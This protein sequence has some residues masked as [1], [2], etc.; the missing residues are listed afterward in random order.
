QTDTALYVATMETAASAVEN[1]LF[2]NIDNTRTAKPTGYPTDNTT[3][4]NAY[5]AKLN[6]SNGQK[7]GPSLV[8]RVMA[9]DSIT[10]A[11][12][13]LY[14][15]AGASTPY[16]TSSSMVTSILQAFSGGGITDGVHSG[17]GASAPVNMLTSGVYDG[18][19]SKDS[20]QNLS[21]KPK[22]YLNFALFDD[23]FNL[24]DENSGVRQVQG[25]IDS[26]VP[27]VLNKTPIKKT[28][29]LYIYTSNE[30]AQDVF[31]DN[32]IVTHNTG[33]LLEETHYYPFGL[34]M[35]GISSNALKSASYPEN[36]KKFQGQEFDNSLDLNWY[37][38]K[39]RNH[40]PQIGR[41]IEIDP[42]ASKYDYNSPYAF[43]EN[44]VTSHVEL[45][46][47]EAADFRIE[48]DLRDVSSGKITGEE[49]A[50]R[51][52]IR[53][54]ADLIAVGGGLIAGGSVVLSFTYPVD[55]QII[56]SA[57]LFGGPSPGA[58][59]SAAANIVAGTSKMATEVGATE[60][61]ATRAKDVHDALP[62]Q[63]QSRTT[64]AVASATTSEGENVTLVASSEPRL[65]PAQRAALRPGE[66]EV[67][68]MGHAEQT[69]INHAN[70]NGMK[71]NE[72]AASRPI[73]P[74]CAAAI[75]NSGAK[76]ASELKRINLLAPIKPN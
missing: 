18:L 56:I 15:N 62:L 47:L 28:G 12:K 68:G 27:L 32:L 70:A 2:S 6:A 25:P 57:A 69:I 4:P 58:P 65:R 37:Q 50:N 49:L 52:D 39:W 1:A 34:T 46:G 20:L 17:T 66:V 26:L 13:A 21:G 64:T 10:I 33:P 42:L 48:R 54:K 23:Q 40:D 73:C 22:A 45:E 44:K 41:F 59:G 61:L 14:K 36:K 38:F 9:G 29:F 53:G 51:I 72:V 11:V 67:K 30:S 43:S 35:A 3:N 60:S 31:F 7:I 8:L 19:K 5:V 75:N 16:T 24:V 74:S 55:A 76:P 71:V 63:T